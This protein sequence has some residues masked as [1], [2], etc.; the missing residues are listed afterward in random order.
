MLR[1]QQIIVYRNTKNKK[2]YDY[3]T[4]VEVPLLNEIIS[5]KP[6]NDDYSIFMLRF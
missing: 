5:K 6:S 4:K 2:F 1:M 3:C